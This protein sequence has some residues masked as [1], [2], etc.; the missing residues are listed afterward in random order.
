MTVLELLTNGDLKKYLRKYLIKQYIAIS[1]YVY[2]HHEEWYFDCS[3]Q[4]FCLHS[5]ID[6]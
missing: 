2:I 3:F 6:V 4:L 1:C 5:K